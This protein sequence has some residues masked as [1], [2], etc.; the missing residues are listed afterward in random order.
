MVNIIYVIDRS[1]S[2]SNLMSDAIGGFNTFLEEQQN[3]EDDCNLT[4]IAFDTEYKVIYDK[5]PI[6]DVKPLTIKDISAR[7]AT[8]LLDTVGKALS[9]IPDE[10][11]VIVFIMTDGE[12]NSSIEWTY[13]S[14]K[15]L[16]QNKIKNG[17]D[18]NFTG[19]GIDVFATGERLGFSV[20]K[21]YRVD[22][23]KEGLD[24]YSKMSSNISANYRANIK[25]KK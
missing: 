22:N 20:D 2:M 10:E 14:V 15:K 24:T 13:D 19:V 9:S 8:A 7:G 3:L 11:N 21:R 18:I 17:W 16:V 4:L 6:Q 5:T 23:S 1:G 12:E 25:A